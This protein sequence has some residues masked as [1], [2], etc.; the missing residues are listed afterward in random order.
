M[1]ITKMDMANTWRMKVRL[2]HQVGHHLVEEGIRGHALQSLDRDHPHRLIISSSIIMIAVMMMHNIV[3][4]TH[5]L[6]VEEGHPEAEDVLLMP[7]NSG[8][9]LQV[10]GVNEALELCQHLPPPLLRIIIAPQGL[11]LRGEDHLMIYVLLR[12]MIFV[13][14][15]GLLVTAEEDEVVVEEVAVVII[16]GERMIVATADIVIVVVGP[17]HRHHH[18]HLV[19]QMILLRMLQSTFESLTAALLE[20]LTVRPHVNR[21]PPSQTR[22]RR[23]TQSI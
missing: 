3:L 12:Q 15:R 10:M 13:L 8:Q 20:L 11:S 23:K 5:Q 9:V 2:E 1:M 4:P 18:H 6:G 14:L 7:I 17:Y 21:T 19:V 16:E 22:Q